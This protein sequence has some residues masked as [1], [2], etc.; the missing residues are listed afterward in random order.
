MHCSLMKHSLSGFPFAPE[1]PLQCGI[2]PHL[3]VS[4]KDTTLSPGSSTG[5]SFCRASFDRVCEG[6]SRRRSVSVCCEVLRSRRLPVNVFPRCFGSSGSARLDV[7]RRSPGVA[8]HAPHLEDEQ[9][10]WNSAMNFEAA[11]P[12]AWAPR[13][14]LE[15][16]SRVLRVSVHREAV[17]YDEDGPTPALQAERARHVRRFLSEGEAFSLFLRAVA[18]SQSLQ[19]QAPCS[20]S[21]KRARTAPQRSRSAPES[22][23]PSISV[24]RFRLSSWKALSSYG[25]LLH[26]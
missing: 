21:S 8:P 12:Q 16:D 6:G 9:R 26:R 5:V 20:D 22:A 19:L 23:L 11:W 7:Q 15:E 1:A 24:R 13:T 3:V 2:Q 14:R 25:G 17:R 10:K 4:S 18:G